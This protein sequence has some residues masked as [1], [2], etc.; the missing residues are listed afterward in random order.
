ME[1]KLI[2]EGKV[3]AIYDLKKYAKK[4]EEIVKIINTI[5]DSCIELAL[6]DD[7]VSLINEFIPSEIIY[8]FYNSKNSQEEK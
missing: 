7:F 5:R 6:F 8:E 1:E 4:Y 3:V 2:S